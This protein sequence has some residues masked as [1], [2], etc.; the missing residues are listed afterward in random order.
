MMQRVKIVAVGDAFAGKTCMFK[1]FC[2]NSFPAE[3]IPTVCIFCYHGC[4][5]SN[6][7]HNVTHDQSRILPHFPINFTRFSVTFPSCFPPEFP[8]FSLWSLFPMFTTFDVRPT[9]NQKVA[10]HRVKL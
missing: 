6:I 8:H 4:C 9:W 10:N 2:S 7:I 1:S 3:Y 5:L